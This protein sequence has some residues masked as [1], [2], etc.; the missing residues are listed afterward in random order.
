M[1]DLAG[2]GMDPRLFRAMAHPLRVQI[3]GELSLPGAI[4][5]P[6][7]FAESACRPLS[8]VAYHFRALEK[9]G[10]IECVNEENVRGSVEHFYRASK[11]A[12]FTDKGWEGLPGAARTQIASKTLSQYIEVAQTA[13]E[14]GAFERRADAHF[15]WGTMEVDEQGWAEMQDRLSKTLSE[16][17]EIGEASA[18]RVREGASGFHAT[19]ALGGFESPRPDSGN[20]T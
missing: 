5:S 20:P 10:L 7:R 6:S 12:L 11:R 13:I 14:G 17:L 15:S 9:F 3:L 8:T 16:M 19:Y 18:T 2:G 4:L 1:A